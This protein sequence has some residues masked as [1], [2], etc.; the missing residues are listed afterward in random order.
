VTGDHLGPIALAVLTAIC[1]VVGI[2]LCRDYRRTVHRAH[3]ALE[4]D[5]QARAARLT[6]QAETETQFAALTAGLFPRGD[7]PS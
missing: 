7:D 3:N 2:A 6:A 4:A 1:A 5:I